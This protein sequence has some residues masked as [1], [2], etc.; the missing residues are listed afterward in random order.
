ML[1]SKQRAYLRGLANTISPTTT[2][3]KEGITEALLSSIEETFNTRELIKLSILDT[4]GLDT[5]EAANDIARAVKAESVQAIGS[6]IVLYKKNKDNPK[7][8]LPRK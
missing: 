2:I 5:R 6:K 1:T 4:A 8:I 3:G 7:I